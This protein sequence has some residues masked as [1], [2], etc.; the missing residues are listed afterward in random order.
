[1]KGSNKCEGVCRCAPLYP[2][3]VEG[4]RTSIFQQASSDMHSSTEQFEGFFELFATDTA[5]DQLPGMDLKKV[6]GRA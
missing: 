1:V 3:E 2:P 6:H 4:H 5:S